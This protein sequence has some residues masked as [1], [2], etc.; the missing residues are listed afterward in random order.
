VSKH[1]LGGRHSGHPAPVQK[2]FLPLDDEGQGSQAD[3]HE[4]G[5]GQDDPGGHELGEGGLVGPVDGL[6]K[7]HRQGGLKIRCLIAKI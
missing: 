3:S 7:H 2:S 5:D 6:F 1:D 4:V